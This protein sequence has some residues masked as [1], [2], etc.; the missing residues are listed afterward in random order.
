VLD[1]FPITRAACGDA[2]TLMG[3]DQLPIV[4]ERLAIANGK[5]K[6]VDVEVLSTLQ[7]ADLQQ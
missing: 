4:P 1:L 2:E 7:V 6:Y 3:D 5:S